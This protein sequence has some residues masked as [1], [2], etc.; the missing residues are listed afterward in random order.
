MRMIYFAPSRR[1][2]GLNTM[3][4]ILYIK[5]AAYVQAFNDGYD[6]GYNDGYQ[7][8]GDDASTEIDTLRLRIAQDALDHLI[9]EGHWNE[10]Y[11]IYRNALRLIAHH[12]VVS[13]GQWEVG[14]KEMVALAR[15]TLGMDADNEDS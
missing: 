7:E 3:T 9:T 15:K 1:A 10:Y 4:D 13:S 8:G 2:L 11:H 6:E 12:P 5:D 14:A